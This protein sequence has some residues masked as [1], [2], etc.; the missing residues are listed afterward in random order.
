M[1]LSQG[2]AVSWSDITTLFT[3]LNSARTKYGFSSV[4]ASGGVGTQV[5]TGAMSTLASGVT[6][7]ASKGNLS[8]YAVINGTIPVVGDLI[9]PTYLKNISTSIS[10]INTCSTYNASQVSYNGSNYTSDYSYNSSVCSCNHY[11]SSYDSSQV[12]YQSSYDSSQV[13]YQSSYNASQVSYSGYN[14]YFT[15]GVYSFKTTAGY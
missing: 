11:Q 8:Q 2:S 12:S 6:E 7:M 14:Y 10:E 1:A 4:S 13:S 9:T 5:T 15:T 3:N